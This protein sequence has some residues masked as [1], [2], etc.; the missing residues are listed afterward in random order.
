VASRV[1][2]DGLRS[3]D[4]QTRC[5]AFFELF[6]AARSGDED[7]TMVGRSTLEVHESLGDPTHVATLR[8]A[9]AD[10]LQVQYVFDELPSQAA[11][12]GR[13][14][15]EGGWRFAYTLWFRNGT[16]VPFDR[17]ASETDMLRFSVVPDHLRFTPGGEFP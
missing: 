3:A 11:R 10:W 14:A 2:A 9:G 7:A 6:S 8:A 12:E 17:L 13:A 4:P 1:A 5:D 16:V 15:W